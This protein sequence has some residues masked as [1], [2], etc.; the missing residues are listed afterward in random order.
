MRTSG[1]LI[2]GILIAVGALIGLGFIAWL[3]QTTREG[4]TSGSTAVFGVIL[5]IGLLTLPLVAAGFYLMRKGAAEAKDIAV[6][7]RQR[8]LLGIVGAR[9]QINIADVVLEM[10]STRDQVQADIYAL[11]SR[12]LYT[13]YVDWAKGTLYSVDAAKLQGSRE[14][15]NCGGA[16]ELGGKGLVKCPYCGAEIFL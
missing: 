2:G 13:G 5:F 10:N 9:G 1:R 6:V 12:G 15:P 16:L 4:M 7:E 8:K 14:C 11:V 3:I